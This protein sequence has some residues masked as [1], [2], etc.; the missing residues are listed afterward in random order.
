[1]KE[2]KKETQDRLALS[3]RHFLASVAASGAAEAAILTTGLPGAAAAQ[4]PGGVAARQSADRDAGQPADGDMVRAVLNINGE[5][6]TLS[7]EPRWS[8]QYVLRDRL[9]L[10]GTKSGCERGEC[11]ACT[12]LIDGIAPVFVHDAGTGSGGNA[13]NDGRGLD[14]RQA[15]G[16]GAAGL[17]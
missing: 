6:H 5:T 4:A 12:V 2:P 1:M 17:C 10:T 14:A 16:S 13:N 11:G 7:V 3:R 8:L 15:I 9:G